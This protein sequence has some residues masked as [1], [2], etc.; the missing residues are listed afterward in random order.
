MSFILKDM[1]H[2][3]AQAQTIASHTS[4]SLSA[5]GGDFLVVLI[6]LAVFFLFARYT[7]RGQFVALL[8][9]LYTGYALYSI[10]PFMR[11]LPTAPPVTALIADVALYSLFVGATYVILRRVVVSD[12]LSVGTISL[13][14]LSFLAATFLIALAYHVFPTRAVYAFTP[15]LNAL[16]ASPDLFFW[17]FMAPLLG[18]FFLGR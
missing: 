12:F 16:F 2:T 7:G 4:F 18:L 13:I 3:L 5:L 11:F 10:F 14:I 15:A 8:I 1:T 9:S 6:L 17:W